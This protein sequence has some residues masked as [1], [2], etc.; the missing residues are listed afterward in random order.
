MLSPQDNERLTRVGPG[1]PMGGLLRRYWMPIGAL[2]EFDTRSI[3]PVRLLG[4]DLV[5]YKDLQGAFG[6]V[7]RHCA[8]R[9]ADLSYGFVEQCGLRC[10]YHGW[11]FDADGSVLAQP[12][13]DVAHPAAHLKDE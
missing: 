3:K 7:D 4:E 10:N 8:H 13:E 5:L 11:L 2:T 12:Y 9:R 1:T 6:L